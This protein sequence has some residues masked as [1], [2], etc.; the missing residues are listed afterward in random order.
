MGSHLG[1][2]GQSSPEKG[3]Q[4]M[5]HVPFL[6]SWIDSHL[7]QVQPW[8]AQVHKPM[9]GIFAYARLGQ[10]FLSLPPEGPA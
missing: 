4:E 9:C 2:T 3:G 7:Q 1:S 10:A 6:E 5:G 8:V